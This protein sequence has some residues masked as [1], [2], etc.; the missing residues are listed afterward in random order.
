VLIGVLQAAGLSRWAPA[1]GAFYLYVDVSEL[2]GDSEAWCRRLLAETGV[3][4]TPGRDF[5]P[6]RGG[7]WVR[8][9]FAGASEDIAE[10]GRRL[11]AWFSR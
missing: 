6:I 2:T 1:D 5:D 11:A 8:L 10:A 3:A 9:S 4:I 7:G